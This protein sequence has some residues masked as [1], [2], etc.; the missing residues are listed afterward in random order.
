MQEQE[1]FDTYIGMLALDEDF[2]PIEIPIDILP[3]EDEGEEIFKWLI[4]NNI[5]YLEEGVIFINEKEAK[6]Y[7]PN[8]FKYLQAM[9]IAE[10]QQALDSLEKQGLVSS[11]VNS[12]GEIVYFLT[13]QGKEIAETINENN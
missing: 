2:A 9:S 4:D 3:G 1:Y 11:S 10:S 8:L 6:E 5:I 12:S 13:D 7:D